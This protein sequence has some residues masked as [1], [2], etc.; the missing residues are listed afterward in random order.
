V[1]FNAGIAGA[2]LPVCDGDAERT[3]HRQQ[4]RHAPGECGGGQALYP[5]S[6]GAAREFV[7]PARGEDDRSL[8]SFT[9]L[10]P[11]RIRCTPGLRAEEAAGL[12]SGCRKRCTNTLA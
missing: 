11:P 10:A 2:K 8:R 6:K 1:Q 12:P 5:I 9:M 3:E 4:R 7:Y